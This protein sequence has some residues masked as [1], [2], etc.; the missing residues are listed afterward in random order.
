MLGVSRTIHGGRLVDY[1]MDLI[2]ATG[3]RLSYEAHPSDGEPDLFLSIVIQ[4][5]KIV[6]ENLKPRVPL[7]VGF[8][9][10]A[11]DRLLAWV[12]KSQQPQDRRV[13]Y[14]YLRVVCTGE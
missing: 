12:D 11:P 5:H 13:E 6:F 9:L 2:R 4:E 10:T 1:E 14:H 7:R 3:D 8:E